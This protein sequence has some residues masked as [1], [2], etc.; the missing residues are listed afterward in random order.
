MT[1]AWG[2]TKSL[3]AL[4]PHCLKS[5]PDYLVD[6]LDEKKKNQRNSLK[7]NELWEILISLERHE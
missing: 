1:Q 3:D 4:R 7:V 6:T 5:L 2:G